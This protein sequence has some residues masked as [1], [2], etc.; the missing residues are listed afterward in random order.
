MAEEAEEE[1]E[2]EESLCGG[3][4]GDGEDCVEVGGGGMAGEEAFR[5]K[6]PE[7]G[8]AL[9]P[10]LELEPTRPPVLANPYPA[11]DE[12]FGEEDEE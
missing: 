10:R 9:E 6:M 8:R 7:E 3:G 4:E 11:R 5:R 2:E 1:E 12:V